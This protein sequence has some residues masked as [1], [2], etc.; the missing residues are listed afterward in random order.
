MLRVEDLPVEDWQL[1]VAT[2]T[3]LGHSAV[4]AEHTYRRSGGGPNWQADSGGEVTYAFVS[5]DPV[6]AARAA[7]LDAA[8]KASGSQLPRQQRDEA[9]VEL[10]RLLGYPECCTRRF[11]TLERRGDNRAWPIESA[12]ATSG[13]G[14]FLLNNLGYAESV[15]PFFP[16][17][18]DCPEATRLMLPVWEHLA[19]SFPELAAELHRVLARVV[20]FAGWGRLLVLE[21]EPTAGGWRVLRADPGS[22]FRPEWRELPGTV[23]FEQQVA[24]RLLTGEL[25]LPTS[26]RVEIGEAEKV[27]CENSGGEEWLVLDFTRDPLTLIR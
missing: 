12:R 15:V 16:C 8:E 13:P 4:R 23:V 24:P 19:G 26:G 10:G 2:Y 18:Y 14:V 25:L 1:G 11:L 21:A 20:L 27:L 3:E 17:R 9:T 22:A 7:Q 6:L 5:R